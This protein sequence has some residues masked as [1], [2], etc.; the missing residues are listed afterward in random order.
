MA[1]KTASATEHNP[2]TL[3]SCNQCMHFKF[4]ENNAEHNSPH[5]LG[6]CSGE[7]WDGSRG[8]WAMFLHHCNA[9][10]KNTLLED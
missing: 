8:Q 3:I 4:F 1:D 9:F 10:E 2:E 7:S 6:E 5:A